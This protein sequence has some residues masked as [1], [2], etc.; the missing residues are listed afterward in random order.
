M[1]KEEENGTV[2]LRGEKEK[3][4]YELMVLCLRHIF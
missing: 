2:K 4:V 3:E 1:W